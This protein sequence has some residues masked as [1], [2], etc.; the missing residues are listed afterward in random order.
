MMLIQVPMIQMTAVTSQW[1]TL[2]IM[3]QGNSM[4][5][6]RFIEN[7]CA[8]SENHTYVVIRMMMTRT[9]WPQF[10]HKP[11]ILCCLDLLNPLMWKESN[12]FGRKLFQSCGFRWQHTCYTIEQSQFLWVLYWKG[13]HW[14][15]SSCAIDDKKGERFVQVFKFLTPLC[16]F[17][18]LIKEKRDFF[19][20]F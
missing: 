2:L 15:R 17:E 16:P 3:M 5:F 14:S 13:Q 19:Y 8:K 7:F 12:R 11:I 6:A 20:I 1:M 9:V 10:N 18:F 4:F